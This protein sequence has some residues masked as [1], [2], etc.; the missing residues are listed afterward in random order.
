MLAAAL[1][2]ACTTCVHLCVYNRGEVALEGASEGYCTFYRN[3]KECCAKHCS[4]QE[5]F[6]KCKV[7]LFN[8]VN[9]I[10]RL[11]LEVCTAVERRSVYLTPVYD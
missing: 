10:A 8:T 2:N 9:Y 7:N 4:K 11:L 3:T 5:C 1:G 6:D